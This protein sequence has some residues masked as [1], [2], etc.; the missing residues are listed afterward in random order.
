MAALGDNK[1]VEMGEINVD[2]KSLESDDVVLAGL[3]KKAVL[4][5][6]DLLLPL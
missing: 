5:V 6:S 4:K 1:S 2:T 3:G